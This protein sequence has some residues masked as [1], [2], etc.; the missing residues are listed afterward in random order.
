MLPDGTEALAINGGAVDG[1]SGALFCNHGDDLHAYGSIMPIAPVIGCIVIEPDGRRYLAGA[2]ADPP[3]L[4]PS[5]CE[6]LGMAQ[7]E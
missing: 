2:S 1:G 5:S 4:R 7:A 6:V 3:W